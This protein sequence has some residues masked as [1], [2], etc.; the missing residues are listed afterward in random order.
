VERVRIG[1]GLLLLCALMFAGKAAAMTEMTGV[2]QIAA[3]GTHTCALTTGG[4]VKCWGSNG[5]GELGN[6]ST[7]RA[8]TPVDVAT[9]SSGVQAIAAGEYH[10]C[11]LTTGGAVKCWGHNSWGQLGNDSTTRARTPVD[12]AMLSGVQ[13][14]AAGAYHTCALTTGGAVKCWGRNSAGQLGNGSTAGARTPV[15]VSTLSSGVQAIAAGAYHTCALAAGGAVKCW[16]YNGYGQLGNGSTAWAM[17]PVDVLTLSSGVQAI[18]AGGD[19]T[20]A[21]TAG[22]AV[23][24]WGYNGY[25]QLGNGSTADAMT[26]V[27]VSTLSSGVQA[28]AAGA[29]H[30]CALTTG[31]AVKCWG[32]KRFDEFGYAIAPA[33]TPVDV[34]ALSSGVQAIAAGGWHTCALTTGGAVKCWGDNEFDQLGNGLGQNAATPVDVATLSSGVQA[35]AAGQAHTCALTTGGA[36]KCWGHNSWGQLGNNST[37]QATTPVDV[38]TLSSGAKAVS[39]GLNHTCALTTGGAVKCWGDNRYAQLGN[40]STAQATTPV[41]VATLS[42]GVQAIA[43]GQAHTCALTTGGAVKCWGYNGYGQLG[44]GSTA[45]AMTPVDVLTLSSGVRAIGVGGYENASHTC[46]LTTGG[47]VKCWGRNFTGQLGNGSTVNATTP[48]DVSTLSSGVQAI[49]AGELHNCAV[50]AGGAVK[51]WGNNNSGQLGNGS[52]ADATTPV[53]VSTLSSGVQAIAAGGYHTCATMGGAV[54][55]WGSGSRGQLGN[56]AARYHTTPVSVMQHGSLPL[57]VTKSGTGAGAV[58]SS[59]AGIDCGATCS[60]SFATGTPVTL[61]AAASGGSVFTGWSGGGCS[62]T[63]TCQVTLSSATT[64]TATFATATGSPTGSANPTSVPFGGQSVQTTSPEATVTLTNV[65]TGPLEVSG[66]A[67][68]NAVFARTHNCT[69]LTLGQSCTATVTFTPTA[70]GAAAANLTFTTIAGNV[71]VPLTGTGEMSLVK[72]YYRAILN[73]APEPGGQ[74]FWEEESAR[75]QALGANINEIWFV[76]ANYFFNSPEYIAANKSDAQF[77][78]DV[79]NTFFNRPPDGGGAAF[80]QSQ[81]DAGLSRE[82]VIFWFMFSNE[83]RTFTQGVFGNTAARPEVDM[84]MDLFRGILNRFPDTPAFN[85]FVGSLR[86]AQCQGANAP[87]AVYSAVNDISY[88]F[89][90]GAPEYAGRNRSNTQYVSDMYN[91]FLRRGGADSEVD[92]WINQ[93]NSSAKDRNQV[94]ADFM[95]SPEFGARVNAVIAAGCLP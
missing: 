3:G 72:H 75:L 80:W 64:V 91:A 36:V 10:T 73:R 77:L 79:Y 35:I 7:T 43:A 53:D 44:N 48:V 84:V 58:A 93:L 94:R 70:A 83:F 30:T 26:P 92:F 32:Y 21:L 68:S 65:G 11:A 55:C 52:T 15:D 87:G 89:L 33:T 67:V 81:M 60:A 57:T 85:A 40:G 62:G 2:S 45:W 47:A 51:C 6:D 25:G 23:K 49:A 76:M 95:A 61:T 24:C 39:T 82:G 16:G 12:V 14:I 88:F 18:A 50:T 74:E 38:W 63:G 8:A 31:G 42:S 1:S 56:G 29:Y 71:V 20:C 27:D 86:S 66:V 37:A 22:G 28:V 46:A 90:F 34:S 69:A 5:F 54:K 4:A 19:H 17:T 78:T 13:A 59:P 9:L 41:D